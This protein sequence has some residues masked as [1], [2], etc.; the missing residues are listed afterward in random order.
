MKNSSKLSFG[1]HLA[2]TIFFNAIFIA[3]DVY[4]TLRKR[5]KEEAQAE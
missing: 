2:W 5:E 1:E 3:I 4:C